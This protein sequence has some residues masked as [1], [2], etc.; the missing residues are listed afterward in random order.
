MSNDIICT[1]YMNGKVVFVTLISGPVLT[2][3][4]SLRDETNEST[5]KWL[6]HSKQDESTGDESEMLTGLKTGHQIKGYLHLRQLNEL[7]PLDPLSGTSRNALL[8]DA[9]RDESNNRH[10]PQNSYIITYFYNLINIFC[11]YF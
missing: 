1:L 7:S 11:F 5:R 6:V 3:G 4:S 9:L 10:N 2:S 8:R